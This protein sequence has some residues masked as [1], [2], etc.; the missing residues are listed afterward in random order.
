MYY[1]GT[2][3]SLEII[4]KTLFGISLLDLHVILNVLLDFIR[5]EVYSWFGN[6][7]R[8]C[9][10]I[11]IFAC[12]CIWGE[13]INRHFQQFL[14]IYMRADGQICASVRYTTFLF[15]LHIFSWLWCNTFVT[16][17]IPQLISNFFTFYAKVFL[18][19]EYKLFISAKPVQMSECGEF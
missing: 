10:L 18:W 2:F 15:T 9:E 17:H 4:L 13:W 1:C 7:Q 8:Y 12:S 16:N 11:S 19:E 5:N 14:F 6:Y 3:T